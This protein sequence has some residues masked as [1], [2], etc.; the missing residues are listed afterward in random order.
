MTDV[1]VFFEHHGVKGMK[2]GQRRAAKRL[3]KADK[4]WE[5]RVAGGFKLST[6]E[7]INIHN[8]A[9]EKSNRIDIP[10]IN[11]KP[12]YKTADFSKDSPLRRK[13]YK[14]YEDKFNERMQEA[15]FEIHGTSPSGLKQIRINKDNSVDIV[16]VKHADGDPK[17]TLKLSDTGHILKFEIEADTMEQSDLLDGFFEHHGIKGMKW[18]LRRKRGA[19]GRVSTEAKRT[20]LIA[21]KHKVHGKKS[22]TNKEL[23]DYNK[24]LELENKFSKLSKRKNEL[25]TG[26]SFVK[27]VL[28]VGATVNLAIAFSKSDAGKHI[29]NAMQR[30][31]TSM[32]RRAASKVI[33]PKALGR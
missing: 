1:D 3:G 33:V 27:E 11:N 29:A 12:E 32:A 25:K 21:D 28:A 20:A 17:I 24:R 8:A 30:H 6:S 4:I 9:A 23:A 15:A 7:Y 5:A 19:N 18:G 16:D 2:W 10:K 31:K 26:H 22:L 14:E 13:Y